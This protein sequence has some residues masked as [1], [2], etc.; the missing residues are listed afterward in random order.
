M[1]KPL[2][3]PSHYRSKPYDA[4]KIKKTKQLEREVYGPFDRECV[5]AVDIALASTDFPEVSHGA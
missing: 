2:L 3:I 1:S 4:V 5:L